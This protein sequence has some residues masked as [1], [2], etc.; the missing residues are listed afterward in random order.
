MRRGA[1]IALLSCSVGLLPAMSGCGWTNA[2][3]PNSK[4]APSPEQ[5]AQAQAVS[6]RAQEAV[7]RGDLEQAK[8]ELSRLVT[9]A[10]RSPEGHQRLGQVLERQNQLAEAEACYSRALELDQDYVSA[11]IGMGRLELLRGNPQS[12]LKRFE[13]AIEIEPHEAT[14]HL[15]LGAVLESLGRT[16]EAQAAY[17]RSLENDPLQAEASRRIAA[18]Q[19]ARAQGARRVD[20]VDRR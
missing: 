18:L 17:F 14:A 20:A 10:P 15:A 6:E 3:R 19:I 1:L 12:A 13:T 9:L 4:N 11:L 16:E 2:R 7:D 8:A 5:A